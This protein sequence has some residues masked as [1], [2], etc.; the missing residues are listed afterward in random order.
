MM[1]VLI[2]DDDSFVCTSLS[3]I[4]NAEDDMEVIGVGYNG[5]DAVELYAKEQP[6]I[7]LIDI[8]M[9]G[10]GGLDAAREI[11]KTWPDARIVFLTTFADDGYIISAL[12]LG[13]RG[14]LIK[15]DVAKI[16]PALRSV[17]VG[18]SVLAGEI[19]ERLDSLM[20]PATVGALSGCNELSEREN[21][22]IALIA[23]GLDNRQIAASLY[24]SEGTVRN[25]ISAI[26]AKFSLKNRTQLAIM[27][28]QKQI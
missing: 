28:Y 1:Q 17:M 4:L 20:R 24:I 22:I 9:P 14:Y 5:D 12:H 19:L 15:Q 27:Y 3:T 23:S 8:Q 7:L 16:A 6:D 11:L 25:Y 18:Q 10:K 21:E 2:V 13:A 26:L